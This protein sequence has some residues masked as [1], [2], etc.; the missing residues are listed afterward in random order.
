M[1]YTLTP[2]ETSF[3]HTKRG[4]MIMLVIEQTVTRLF[5][6]KVARVSVT[7]YANVTVRFGSNT[8]TLTMPDSMWAEHEQDII[9]AAMGEDAV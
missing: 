6:P 4:L 3:R 8:L 7:Q 5:V 1:R 2:G 9:A